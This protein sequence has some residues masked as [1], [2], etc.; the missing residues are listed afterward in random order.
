M[1][2]MIR[3]Y[4]LRVIIAITVRSIGIQ[5]HHNCR[6]F[7]AIIIDPER[8]IAYTISLQYSCRFLQIG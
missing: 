1:P 5:P 2:T 3:K 6:T 7:N 4:S 8:Q